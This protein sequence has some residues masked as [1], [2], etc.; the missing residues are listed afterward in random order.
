VSCDLDFTD[1]EVTNMDLLGVQ[2][3][4]EGTLLKADTPQAASVY[5]FDPRQF[6]RYRDGASKYEQAT[7]ETG[8][9]LREISAWTFHMRAR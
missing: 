3:S 6:P 4:L 1:F 5:R 2:H 7:F 8:A 9:A